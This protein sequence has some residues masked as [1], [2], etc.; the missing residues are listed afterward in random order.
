MAGVSGYLCLSKSP[1]V[2][3]AMM[4][5]SIERHSLLDIS[6]YSA[7]TK[8]RKALSATNESSAGVCAGY[9]WFHG[10]NTMR[11]NTGIINL[12]ASPKTL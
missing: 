3:A 4:L 11:D 5:F 8:I 10:Y 2:I 6:R 9:V 7:L 12:V 1:A